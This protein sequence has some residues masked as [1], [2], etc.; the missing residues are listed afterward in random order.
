MNSQTGFKKKK[1]RNRT[2]HTDYSTVVK[3]NV[4]QDEWKKVIKVKA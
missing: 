4:T 3:N 1:N 2:H